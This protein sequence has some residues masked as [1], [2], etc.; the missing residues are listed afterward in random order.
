MTK[1]MTA[2]PPK[3]NPPSV[4]NKPR[5]LKEMLADVDVKKR[6]EE[7][8]GRAAGA[9]M[10]N[11][12]SVS[13]GSQALQESNPGSIIASAM[14]AAALELPI[15]PS[16]GMAAI[17]PYKDSNG[18]S[19]AQFQIMWR[20]FVQLAFRSGQYKRLHLA[21]VYEGQLISWSELEGSGVFNEGAKKSDRVIGHYFVFE[22]INGAVKKEY[23]SV[24]KSLDHGKRFSQSFYSAKGKWCDDPTLPKD[25]AGR[26][27]IDK[28]DGTLTE[29]SGSDA[30]CA[31][32]LVK[33]TLSKWG[34]LSTKMQEAV[35]VDQAAID[36]KGQPRYIDGVATP[37]IPEGEGKTYS[38]PKELAGTA[39]AEGDPVEFKVKRGS[40]TDLNG[41][42]CFVLVDASKE[43][44]KYFTDSEAFFNLGKVATDA[45]TTLRGRAIEKQAGDVKVRW[46]TA[47][48]PKLNG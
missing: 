21:R 32:T 42:E 8:M 24:R 34:P 7:I 10:S 19:V 46:L 3:S 40:K 39:V 37:G 38:E 12:L 18:S 13:Q 20:G 4:V 41:E 1:D 6:F 47:L 16:L 35:K 17:V 15:E 22:L 11:L 28:W 30:M 45:G 48:E 9:F 29:G 43:G 33:M 36:D 2:A 23:W 5:T 26:V 44:T 25:K 31:K 14:K 27:E